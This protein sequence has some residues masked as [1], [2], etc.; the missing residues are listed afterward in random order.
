MSRLKFD[1]DI[2]MVLCASKETTDGT[3]TVEFVDPPA[4]SQPGDRIIGESLIGQPY[5]M[6]KCDKS[7]AFDA[8]AP[9]LKVDD[10]GVAY[11][12][13]HR[14]VCKGMNTNDDGSIIYESCTVPTLRDAHIH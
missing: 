6:S 7:K 13:T 10:N 1:L 12:K 2:G 3:T 14:L 11:W 4:S 8:I 5:T 9:D